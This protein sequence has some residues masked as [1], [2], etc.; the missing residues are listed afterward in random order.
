MAI[1]N[2]KHREIGNIGNI[3]HEDKQYKAITQK[4]TTQTQKLE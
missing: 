3:R 1:N 4:P 2:G